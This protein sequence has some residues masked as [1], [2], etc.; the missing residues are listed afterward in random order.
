LVIWFEPLGYSL[1]CYTY[2]SSKG[3][4]PITKT[5]PFFIL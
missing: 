3:N 4:A 2:G 1:L 5:F